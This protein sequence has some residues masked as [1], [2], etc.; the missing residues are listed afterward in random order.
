MR[1]MFLSS[2]VSLLG[3]LALA[4]ACT[5][6]TT[7]VDGSDGGSSS[8]DAGKKDG[9]STSSSGGVDAGEEE[10]TGDDACG[11]EAD[12]NGCVSCCAKAYQKGA[13]FLLTSVIACGCQGTGSK[14]DAGAGSG[15]CAADCAATICAASAKNADQKCGACL[16]KIVAQGG[17]CYDS[18]ATACQKNA[19]C[20]ANQG[21]LQAQC[22]SKQ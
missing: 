20:T 15:P 21:C 6:T 13:T 9:G 17:S 5:T 18:V 12:L 7:V 3:V 4:A 1:S 10:P 11:A 19:D 14:V 16:D 8:G 22:A 2:T